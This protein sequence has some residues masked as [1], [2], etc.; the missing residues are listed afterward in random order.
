M[1]AHTLPTLGTRGPVVSHADMVAPREPARAYDHHMTAPGEPDARGSRMS[2]DDR[3]VQILGLAR[4]LFAAEGYHHVSMDD[5]AV[6]AEVTKPVLYRHFPSKLDLYLAVIDQRGDDLLAAVDTALAALEPNHPEDGRAVVAAVVRAYFEF[7][8]GA[9]EASSLLFESDI[10][11]DPSV[12]ERVDRAASS[13]SAHISGVLQDVSGLP[14]AQTELLV[15][16]LTAMAQAA[17]THH[18]RHRA[19]L[20]LD[21]AA[22]LVGR[23][24]WGGIAGLVKPTIA[25]QAPPNGGAETT[26]PAG[27]PG[28]EIALPATT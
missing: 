21:L 14:A 2:R 4:D 22:G 9:G 5:I 7:V 25:G 11:R 17:A 12:R 13:V 20:G 24:A 16:G 8:A 27:R 23:L 19:E 28:A 10:L 18:L 15:S 26:P 6:Q 3:R 1:D